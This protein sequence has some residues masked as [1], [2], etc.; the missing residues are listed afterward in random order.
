MKDKTNKLQNNNKRFIELLRLLN[1]EESDKILHRT[2]ILLK[3]IIT[4]T[5]KMKILISY[6]ILL[7]CLILE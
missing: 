6:R 2:Y 1:Y 3:T 5:L 7:K 4:V